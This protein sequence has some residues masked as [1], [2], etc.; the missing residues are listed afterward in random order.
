MKLDLNQALEQ[1]AQAFNTTVDKLYPLL[2]K[3]AYVSGISSIGAI[4]F[5]WLILGA[6]MYFFKKHGIKKDRYD[7]MS[8][9]TIIL[10]VFTVITAIA[11][12][13]ITLVAGS[14][15]ITALINPEYWALK[16]VLYYIK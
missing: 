5:S 11:T 10:I 12:V 9:G 3:Q 13:I 1:L 15:A 14:N 4:L 7:I 6:L 2:I 16:E 8:G